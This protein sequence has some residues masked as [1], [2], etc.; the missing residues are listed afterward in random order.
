MARTIKKVK[1]SVSTTAACPCAKPKPRV[2]KKPAERVSFSAW[3]NGAKSGRIPMGVDLFGRSVKVSWWR[4][5][6]GS[7]VTEGM[8]GR[9]VAD[10]GRFVDVEFPAKAPH[11]RRKVLMRRCDL[12]LA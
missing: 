12:V 8:V 9:V 3:T 2:A 10:E 11:H 6:N 1:R 7:D 5:P 4:K